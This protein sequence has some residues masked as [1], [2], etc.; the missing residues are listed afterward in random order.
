MMRQQFLWLAVF[1]AGALLPHLMVSQIAVAEEAKPGQNPAGQNPAERFNRLDSNKDGKLTLD[2]LPD[3]ARDRLRPVFERLVKTELNQED[4]TKAAERAGGREGGPPNGQGP[5]GGRPGGGPGQGGGPNGQGGG[6]GGP[7]PDPAEMF[8]RLDANKDG[9]LTVDELPEQAK[10]RLSPLF[11]RLGKTELT[12]EDF[13]KA[14][15]Q[16][17]NRPGGPNG[18]PG[19]P[20]NGGP[21]GPGQNPGENF[22]RLD[23]NKDG[24]LTFDE[25]P[26]QL[27][28]RLRPLFQG[29]GK[30][31][32]T[33]E[34]FIRAA[35][36]AGG[37]PG[38]PPNGGPPNGGPPNGGPNGG[39]GGR[40]NGGP[41]GP[42]NENGGPPNGGAGN[43]GQ[44][45]QSSS[46][47][48]NRL[49]VN[50]DGKVTL[51]EVPANLRPAVQRMLQKAG[52][53]R[54]DA[55]TEEDFSKASP[56]SRPGG[57]KKSKKSKS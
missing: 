30:N 50:K 5:A 49:D 14:A 26:D 40:P 27:K 39:F 47:A 13:M 48:F 23:A 45:G 19:G 25:L 56:Q 28:D 46:A 52:K 11:Q 43:G 4:F 2:E 44:G 42:P 36:R 20:P 15:E 1:G 57:E 51:S 54:D 38:G 34:E 10:E 17:G 35:E 22:N 3:E 33:R 53:G 32:I 6:A 41:G 18:G 8:S 29:L 37:R 31:E 24:K 9:K 16:R 12:R 21:G 55:L 7:P